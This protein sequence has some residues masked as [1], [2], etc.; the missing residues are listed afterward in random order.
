MARDFSM[1][2]ELNWRKLEIR[3]LGWFPNQLELIFRFHRR[4]KVKRKQF[5]KYL[6]IG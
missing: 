2:N 4:E 5:S 6:K 1:K 3:F